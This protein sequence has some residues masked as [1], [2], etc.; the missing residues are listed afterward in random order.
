MNSWGPDQNSSGFQPRGG[1]GRGYT[2]LEMDGDTQ[3]DD[4]CKERETYYQYCLLNMLSATY[5]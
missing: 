4:P 3:P 1:D 5:S 2:P